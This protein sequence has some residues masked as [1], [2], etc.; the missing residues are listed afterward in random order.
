MGFPYYIIK[1]KAMLGR[2]VPRK[3]CTTVVFFTQVNSEDKGA[4]H[5]WRKLSGP[6]TMID[7]MR[8]WR[9][10]TGEA[11]S[12]GQTFTS[13]DACC[14]AGTR[15]PVQ[16]RPTEWYSL[17]L[18]GFHEGTC[19]S[20]LGRLRTRAF[21][22]PSGSAAALLRQP[23]L[24]ALPKLY[25]WQPF[26]TD[27]AAGMLP[28][29]TNGMLLPKAHVCFAVK[30]LEDSRVNRKDGQPGPDWFSCLT[31][32]HVITPAVPN[33]GRLNQRTQ[34]TTIALPPLSF[35]GPL[36]SSGQGE[37]LASRTVEPAVGF[38]SFSWIHTSTRPTQLAKKDLE[39]DIPTPTSL[40]QNQA[41]CLTQCY[42][43]PGLYQVLGW[44]PKGVKDYQ[45]ETPG[46][47]TTQNE[48]SKNQERHL[49]AG[50]LSCALQ[51]SSAVQC[52]AVR[53]KICPLQSTAG[54][55]ASQFLHCSLTVLP[56]EGRRNPQRHVAPVLG[57]QP[58]ADEAASGTAELLELS[59]CS[60]NFVGLWALPG[61]LFLQLLIFPHLLRP[62]QHGGKVLQEL[63]FLVLRQHKGKKRPLK[64]SMPWLQKHQQD[65]MWS[66]PEVLVSMRA[67]GVPPPP[68]SL[69]VSGEDLKTRK[70]QQFSSSSRDHVIK[71]EGTDTRA[72]AKTGPV[73][74][75]EGEWAKR[76]RVAWV[77]LGIPEGL[78]P[79]DRCS[80]TGDEWVSRRVQAQFLAARWRLGAS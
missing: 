32:Q 26:T 49:V 24:R 27:L 41:K 65:N 55:L 80:G 35:V 33:P 42:L 64:M 43:S 39:K 68:S 56:F 11:A 14:L 23:R 1:G 2:L 3:T 28:K 5:S 54:T 36:S 21:L 73:R 70:S 13:P 76:N 61:G 78:G 12:W 57:E 29:K 6:M 19:L 46:P 38:F 71:G 9:G 59:G 8:P 75:A 22:S 10:I 79:A 50:T 48:K 52:Q 58:T 44:P 63:S 51:A 37:A 20:I 18:K 60:G 66:K 62:F 4:Q 30:E 72:Q 77:E 16:S 53:I 74:P 7:R 67:G 34:A 40:L 31:R 47:L 69:F 45:K 25:L 17:K 15:I